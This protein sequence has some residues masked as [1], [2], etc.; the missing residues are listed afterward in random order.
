MEKAITRGLS[1]VSRNHSAFNI[2][3]NLNVSWR[4]VETVLILCY[5]T[6]R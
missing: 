5:H 2:E 1:E 3:K 6:V 4:I